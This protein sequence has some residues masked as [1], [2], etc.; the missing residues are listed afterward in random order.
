[1]LLWQNYTQC[2]QKKKYFKKGL[3]LLCPLNT[4][5]VSKGQDLLLFLLLAPG[6]E[7]ETRTMWTRLL[8]FGH[9]WLLMMYMAGSASEQCETNPAGK[10]LPA[11]FSEE[12]QPPSVSFLWNNADSFFSSQL[13]AMGLLAFHALSLILNV[14][15]TIFSLTATVVPNN[16]VQ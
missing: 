4:N 11:F 10:K 1:M 5:C 2:R 13:V 14:R 8:E 3:V 12:K 15:L 16:V 6:H 7:K 9:W